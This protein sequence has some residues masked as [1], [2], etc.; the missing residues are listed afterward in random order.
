MITIGITG[1]IGSGKSIVSTLMELSGIPVYIADEESKRL[2]QK[3]PVIRKGLTD[4]FG[5][6]IYTPNGID[7]KKLA[8]LIFN[9]PEILQKVNNIIHPEVFKDFISWAELQHKN[10]CALESAILFESGFNKFTD[11][12]L[13]V[14]A[15][16]KIR[17]QRAMDRDHASKE[18][19]KTRVNN[20]L[21]DDI[22]KE[23][24]N[25]I[26][27]N[28]GVRALIPQVK[29]FIEKVQNTEENGK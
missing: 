3:S 18:E 9:D 29:A 7:K 24:G 15:P 6:T 13:L 4:L 2:T 21:P 28:D 10:I 20:Q 11:I 17:I 1:G 12:T 19:V 26:I 25:Y 27:Y 23:Q 14:Y 8:G 5:E 22:K 16:E